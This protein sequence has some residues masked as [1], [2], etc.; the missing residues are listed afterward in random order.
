[1]SAAVAAGP[2]EDADAARM[3]GDRAAALRLLR[4][5]AEGGNAAAQTRLG[6]VYED[7][8]LLAP[9]VEEVRQNYTAAM[10]WYQLAAKQGDPQAQGNIGIMYSYGKGV[11]QDFTEAVKWYRLAADQAAIYMQSLLG[12]LYARGAEGVPQDPVAA[13]M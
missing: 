7:F 10:H 1:V 13:H 4:P 5:L 9:E 3:A 12:L 2:L 6:R 11:P 8:A